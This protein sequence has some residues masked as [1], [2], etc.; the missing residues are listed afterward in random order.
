MLLL[1]VMLWTGL[2]LGS[3]RGGVVAYNRYSLAYRRWKEPHKQHFMVELY[4][5]WGRPEEQ[6]RLYDVHP[7]PA[8]ERLRVVAAQWA[9]TQE[10]VLVLGPWGIIAG[11]VVWTVGRGNASPDV[12]VAVAFILATLV[13]A[14]YAQ[15]RKRRVGRAQA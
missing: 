9:R 10:R 14:G 7:D 12:S 8:V 3:M 11:M 5:G 6:R 4:M 2:L 13:V 1:L 15:W